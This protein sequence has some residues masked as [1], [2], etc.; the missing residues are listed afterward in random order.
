MAGRIAIRADDTAETLMSRVQAVE[1]QIYPQAAQ[2]FAEG[3]VTYKG[4]NA[5]LD[6]KI[7]KD[8][9]TLDY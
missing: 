9:L 1:H 2:L 3:R 5:W 6:G 8:P 7:M 4:G